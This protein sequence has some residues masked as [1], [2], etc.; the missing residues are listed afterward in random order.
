MQILMAP[1]LGILQHSYEE[2]KSKRF[3]IFFS[4]IW[5]KLE[6]FKT[7]RV[8]KYANRSSLILW[9]HRCTACTDDL[10][11][12]TLCV[13]SFILWSVRMHWRSKIKDFVC[14]S[15]LYRHTRRHGPWA[16]PFNVGMSILLLFD[17][18]RSCGYRRYRYLF[19]RI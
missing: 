11:S 6:W 18:C 3:N 2:R 14:V 13:P 19:E 15:L 10:R 8:C 5:V 7:N 1:E 17:P 16:C 4:F 9:S 12:R